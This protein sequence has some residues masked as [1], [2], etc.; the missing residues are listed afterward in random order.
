MTDFTH[1]FIWNI[2]YSN[3]D[4]AVQSPKVQNGMKVVL[5]KF[6]RLVNLQK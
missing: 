1:I 6:S 5:C 2:C 3:E 4:S